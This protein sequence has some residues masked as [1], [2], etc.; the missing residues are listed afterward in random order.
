[1]RSKQKLVFLPVSSKLSYKNYKTN[2]KFYEIE[3]RRILKARSKHS[4][5]L[6]KIFK[7]RNLKKKL[8]LKKHIYFEKHKFSQFVLEKKSFKD[9]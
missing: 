9:I 8:F 4:A 3:E 7:F 2:K 6:K 5:A 1:M